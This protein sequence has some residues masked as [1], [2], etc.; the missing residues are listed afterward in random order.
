MHGPYKTC[1]ALLVADRRCSSLQKALEAMLVDYSAARILD[2]RFD[3]VREA[4]HIKN[5]QVRALTYTH[6]CITELQFPHA[7]R[8]LTRWDLSSLGKCALQC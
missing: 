5:N 4:L 2:H 8:I 7:L 1:A 6:T 3:A